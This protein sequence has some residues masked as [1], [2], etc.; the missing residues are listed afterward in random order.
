MATN[1]K[2]KK[3]SDLSEATDTAGFWIFGSKTVGG[4]VT[5]VKFA[6]DSIKSLFGISQDKGQSTTLAP[7]LKLFTDETNLKADK[8]NAEGFGI[9]Y[10]PV[11]MF[12]KLYGADNVSD[13]L[14]IPK[15][16]GNAT[17]EVGTYKMFAYQDQEVIRNK[18][19]SKIGITVTRV[20]KLSVLKGQ[21]YASPTWTYDKITLT[22][23]TLGYQ[24]F[25][26]NIT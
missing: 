24:E 25:P 15:T 21:N 1:I 4:V 16:T 8:V 12:E 10:A 5:S 11:D 3:V 20:G 2:K 6:F 18:T 23:D 14:L 13:V 22:A 9:Q 26:V 7:S 19:I 17:L